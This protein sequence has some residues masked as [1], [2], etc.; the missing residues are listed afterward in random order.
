[1]SDLFDIIRQIVRNEL[2]QT[3]NAELGVVQEQH[4]HAAADDNDN[5]ACTVVLRNSGIVLPR[6]PV[7]TPVI[8]IAAIPNVN[9][10]VLVQ[11][12]GGDI[13]APVITGRLYNEEDRP[14]PNAAGQ[15][16]SHL[17]LAAADDDAVQLQLVSG[18][19]R[20]LRLQL[21]AGL[22]IECKDDD[23]VIVLEVDGGKATVQIDRDGAVTLESNGSLSIKA[24][25][26]TVNGSSIAIEADG[27]LKLKGSTVN[28]N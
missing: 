20:S 10:L 12:I 28:I 23:P 1:V 13:H 7:A 27:E 17:P 3:R 25:D 8:G 2:A 22:K 14:P 6:V 18:A 5:Y 11:F 4:P 26:I 24:G 16:V 19:E 15:W 21:G 9:D